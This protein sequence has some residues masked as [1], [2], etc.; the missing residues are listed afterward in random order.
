[1]ALSPEHQALRDMIS[2]FESWNDGIFK[3]LSVRWIVEPQAIRDA[4][5]ILAAQRSKEAA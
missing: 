2:L 3:K 4:R 5:A 1:M